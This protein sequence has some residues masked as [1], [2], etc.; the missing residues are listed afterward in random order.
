MPL[1][2]P[3]SG[4]IEKEFITRCMSELAGEFEDSQRLAVCYTQWRKKTEGKM[5]EY[6]SFKFEV[7]SVD[8]ASGE[9]E[10]IASA[11][12]KTPDKVNDI[13]QPGAFTK[14]ISE[15]Q[16]ETMLTF[17]P[18]NPFSPVGQGVINEG[19]EGLYVKGTLLRGIQKGEEA[20]LLLKA[21]VIKH[22]SIGYDAIKWQIKDGVR[23]LSE[24]KLYEIGLVPGNIAVDN[25][26]TVTSVKAEL[27]N[28]LDELEMELKEGRILSKA[29]L[30]KIKAAVAALQALLEAADLEEQPPQ[31]K[32]VPPFTDLPLADR[33]TAWDSAAAVKRVRDWAGGD[34]IDWGKYRKA[35]FWYDPQNTELFGSYKLPYADMIGGD[36][37]AIPQAV[38][39]VA[40]VLRGARGGVNI[41]DADKQKIIAQINRYYD[42]MDMTSPFK[43]LPGGW[44]PSLDTPEAMEAAQLDMVLAKVQ[45]FDVKAAEARINEILRKLEV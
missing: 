24:V 14:T 19:P 13:V 45:G 9:F 29:S 32:T 18:H 10:G 23:L 43:A 16:G 5:R 30:D 7:K 31:G 3:N 35:F 21:K 20:Y 1:P 4:E 17:P 41:P 28:R 8:E 36:L 2:K 6:K 37:K 38:I 34:N 26:A 42:K 12:R 33:D 25:R 22:L 27:E 15:N 44:E 40:G 39:A 11:F